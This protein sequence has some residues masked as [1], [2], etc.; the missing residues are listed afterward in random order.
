MKVTVTREDIRK[1]RI[2]QKNQYAA[3]CTCPIA[4]ALKR[5]K[6]GAVYVARDEAFLAGRR[7]KLPSKVVTFID[8]F[9]FVKPVRS[10]S[11]EMEQ[12]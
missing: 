11:F 6:K 9:D 7:Y 10:F 8:K 1:A 3:T 12:I 4:Q 5:K 2:D